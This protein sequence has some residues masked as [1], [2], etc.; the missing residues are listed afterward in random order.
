[1]HDFG[2]RVSL[3]RFDE[4]VARWQQEPLRDFRTREPIPVPDW[5]QGMGDQARAGGANSVSVGKLDPNIAAGLGRSGAPDRYAIE[6]HRMSAHH[7]AST[8]G[9]NGANSG[10]MTEEVADM[11]NAMRQPRTYRGEPME[12]SRIRG[13]LMGDVRSGRLPPEAT[14]VIRR[15]LTAQ[16][17]LER[18]GQVN[19][20][21]RLE[22]SNPTVFDR[23]LSEGVVAQ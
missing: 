7:G 12:W 13:N 23:P 4:T 6:L 20:Y 1:M 9:R 21:Y 11:I 19:P 10:A 3:R 18:E 2:E 22:Q 15:G 5:V 14:P 17:R 16:R 8:V